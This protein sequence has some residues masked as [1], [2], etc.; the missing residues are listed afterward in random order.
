MPGPQ[1]LVE[2]NFTPIVSSNA[3]VKAKCPF[4][5]TIYF[6]SDFAGPMIIGGNGR[7]MVWVRFVV[8]LILLSLLIYD[9]IFVKLSNGVV[10]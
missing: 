10:A 8:L 6:S 2:A 1:L 5:A 7:L 9:I 4:R 3:R